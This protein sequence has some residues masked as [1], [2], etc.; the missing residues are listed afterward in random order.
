MSQDFF[1]SDDISELSMDEILSSIRNII[2]EK[3]VAENPSA[4]FHISSDSDSD[5]DTA[6][7]DSSM[8]SLIQNTD[9]KE[10]PKKTMPDKAKSKKVALEKHV[11][12]GD[13]EKNEI[14]LDGIGL[15]LYDETSSIQAVSEGEELSFDIDNDRILD[16]V[17]L[18]NAAMEKIKNAMISRPAGFD[19][20]SSL[21]ENLMKN[22]SL[23]T[24]AEKG[25]GSMPFANSTEIV[26]S[27]DKVD[28][29]KEVLSD[30]T[31]RSVGKEF[32]DSLNEFETQYRNLKADESNSSSL[33]PRVDFDTEQLLRS[34]P[35]D[36]FEEVVRAVLQPLVQS[37]LEKNLPLITSVLV[38]EELEK[39]KLR[40]DDNSQR[41]PQGLKR[42]S[43]A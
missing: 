7:D 25:A 24:G 37:W 30:Q 26:S 22:I 1:D 3:A 42:K 4:V 12:S 35:L 40:G 19:V 39:V 41:D 16:R 17:A 38:Q 13:V 11:E 43:V 27:E 6:Q 21:D 29:N 34:L 9:N 14:S 33:S 18:S 15:E 20:T 5:V 31:G 10:A 8:D 2:D 28:L 36:T 32:S 23:L